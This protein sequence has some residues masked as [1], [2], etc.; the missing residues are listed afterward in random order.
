MMPVDPLAFASVFLN[1]FCALCGGIACAFL[2]MKSLFKQRHSLAIFFG[3]FFVKMSAQS[4][5][6]AMRWFG[7]GGDWPDTLG[8]ALVLVL[9]G[10][11]IFI[12]W[13][14]WESSLLKVG[15]AGVF[16]DALSAFPMVFS[17][18]LVNLLRGEGPFVTYIGP[19]GPWSLVR[20]LLMVGAFWILL[21]LVLPLLRRFVN[22][23][24]KYERLWLILFCL[25]MAFDMSTQLPNVDDSLNVVYSPSYFS[26]IL[27]LPIGLLVYVLAKRR[28]ARKRGERLARTRA[29]MAACD[30][31]LRD[32]S[33][34]LESSR[35][36]LDEVANR[37]DELQADG[38]R[39]DLARYLN[40]MR[41]TC[42]RLRFGTYSDNPALDVVLVNYEERF[43]EAGVTVNYRISPL[44]CAGEQPALS[45]QA[46]LE[47]ALHMHAGEEPVGLRAFRRAN[48]VLFEIRVPARRA[49][50]L[51]TLLAR[52]RLLA[53]G[54]TV[55]AAADGKGLVAR[56]LLE[57]GKR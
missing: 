24:F 2:C 50:K 54:A 10:I 35:K 38:V 33:A 52:Y 23:D 56:A 20:P 7:L 57:D 14:V 1:S 9:A 39:D 36:T 51:S 17:L 46:L 15:V 6:D 26:A 4:V 53:P 34:F 11:I 40:G 31:A 22:H 44:A 8:H 30:D 37:I 29:L 3:F 42:D 18:A 16:A 21:R 48:Q 55:R 12:N 32:Q 43:R 47:W 5:F 41:A 13:Y 28:M 49:R 25:F 19:F 27:M 45:A